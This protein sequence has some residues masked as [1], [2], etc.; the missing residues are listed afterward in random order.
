MG[1]PYSIHLYSVSGLTGFET[2]GGLPGDKTVIIQEILVYSN[3]LVTAQ[4]FC[5][6]VVTGG[7]FAYFEWTGPASTSS[8]QWVGKKVVA[9]DGDPLAL[10]IG[11][12]APNEPV[13]VEIHGAIL[14]GHASF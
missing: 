12:N 2:V 8:K 7:T 13:D 6:D 11:L 4:L 3:P 1:L 9:I 5:M 10:F 14:D